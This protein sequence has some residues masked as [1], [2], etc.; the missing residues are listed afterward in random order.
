MAIIGESVPRSA[1]FISK[2][3]YAA[4]GNDG[5]KAFYVEVMGGSVDGKPGGKRLFPA[6]YN[7][8]TGSIFELIIKKSMGME[9]MPDRPLFSDPDLKKNPRIGDAASHKDGGNVI[10]DGKAS[11]AGIDP[12]Q[13]ADYGVI[14][15]KPVLG[16]FKSEDK[17]VHRYV[18]VAYAVPG[19]QELAN[20]VSKQIDGIIRKQDVRSKF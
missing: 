2:S 8:V 3:G 6:K 15:S 10:V 14:I 18:A 20:K 7:G 17:P 19:S 16:L 5:W 13:C 12:L 1:L 9:L 11:D 4:L